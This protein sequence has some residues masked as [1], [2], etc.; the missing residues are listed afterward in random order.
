M[1]AEIYEKDLA[2]VKLGQKVE[3]TVPAYPGEVFEGVLC[4]IDDLVCEVTRTI[5]VRAEVD[6]DPCKLKPRMFADVEI[7]LNGGEQMLV[8]PSAAILEEGD[9]K[10][11]F[12]K[13]GDY[14][15]RREVETGIVDG[16]YWPILKGL[17]A[18]EEV[19]IEGNHELKSKLKEE[20]LKAAHVH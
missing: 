16:D 18:G 20:V 8:V 2:K 4:Y 1:D 11:L 7:L 9:R 6:N 12:V 19:V 5:T 15:V 17:D 3:I 13:E 10:I 14:F